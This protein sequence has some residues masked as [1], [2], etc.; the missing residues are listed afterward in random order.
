MFSTYNYKCCFVI[1]F[2]GFGEKTPATVRSSNKCLS[3][4]AF[5]CVCGGICV[6]RPATTDQQKQ[7]HASLNY[8][9]NNL[10]ANKS[11][12]CFSVVTPG[13]N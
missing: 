10:H 7:R 4:K 2:T 12:V 11:A 6:L 3:A 9:I 5:V 13:C 8:A 1:C